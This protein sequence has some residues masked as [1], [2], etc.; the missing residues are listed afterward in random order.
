MTGDERDAMTGAVPSSA[1]TNR[2]WASVL[3]VLTSPALLR[4]G[5]IH[6]VDFGLETI[7][8][9]RLLELAETGS[10]GE[11]VLLRAACDLFN[12]SGELRLCELIGRLDDVNL[13][14][15][16]EAI[17]LHRGLHSFSLAAEEGW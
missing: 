9:V 12:S 6:H 17:E 1:M 7:D 14:C 11:Q 10:G 4:I 15:V 3:H 2:E 8:V 5:A 13:R 16:L